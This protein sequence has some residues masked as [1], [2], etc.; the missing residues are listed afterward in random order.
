MDPKTLTST[1][2]RDQM[3]RILDEDLVFHPDREFVITRRD[4]RPAAV[5]VS[6]ELWAEAMAA[7]AT[8]RAAAGGTEPGG[9]PRLRETEHGDEFGEDDGG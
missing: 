1:E 8:V 9:R 5:L 7:L 3:K 6:P 4:H 2:F